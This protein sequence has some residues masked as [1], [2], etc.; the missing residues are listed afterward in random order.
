MINVAFQKTFTLM[1]KLLWKLN[2]I[3]INYVFENKL[4]F[5]LTFDNPIN[6]CSQ[7]W[8]HP[9]RLAPNLLETFR[10]KLKKTPCLK[11]PKRRKYSW[12]NALG[13]KCSKIMCIFSP[14][15]AHRMITWTWAGHTDEQLPSPTKWNHISI[16]TYQIN[17][18]QAKM[19]GTLFNIQLA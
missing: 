9:K 10:N 11:G 13:E 18:I 12:K 2:P 1:Y 7:A 4:T 17:S 14:S 8:N 19:N 5:K 3:K 15:E 6:T 16:L